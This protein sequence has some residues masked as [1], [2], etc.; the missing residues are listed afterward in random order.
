[1]PKDFKLLSRYG[2]S[3]IVLIQELLIAVGTF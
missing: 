3:T 1:M 2:V